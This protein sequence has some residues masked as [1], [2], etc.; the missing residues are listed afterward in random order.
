MLS[1]FFLRMTFLTD[2]IEKVFFFVEKLFFALKSL[3]YVIRFSFFFFFLW[4][5]G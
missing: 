1:K 2:V 4:V 5:W 3:V